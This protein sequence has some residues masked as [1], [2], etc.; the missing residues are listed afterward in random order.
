MFSM[1]M[2]ALADGK[3]GP[4]GVAGRWVAALLFVAFY[5]LPLLG[6]G[7]SDALY[8]K[9]LPIGGVKADRMYR[10]QTQFDK[11]QV[12]DSIFVRFPTEEEPHVGATGF[13]VESWREDGAVGDF[14]LERISYDE[15]AQRLNYS[16]VKESVGV[17]EFA[18]DLPKPTPQD[19]GGYRMQFKQ[20]GKVLLTKVIW[21]FLDDIELT[22]LTVYSGCHELKIV[23]FFSM[24]NLDISLE[25]FVY[26]NTRSTAEVIPVTKLGDSYRKEFTW[27]DGSGVKLGEFGALMRVPIPPPENVGVNPYKKMEVRVT[28][29]N[30][31]DRVF[32]TVST[33]EIAPVAVKAGMRMAICKDVYAEPKS[34][35][36]AGEKPVGECPFYSQLTAETENA[37]RLVWTIRN[38]A[39]AARRGAADTIF[40]ESVEPTSRQPVSPPYTLFSA[41]LY[42]VIL[43]AEN[44][45]TQCSVKDSLVV[46]IDSSLISAQAIPNV[47]TPNGDG[48][49]DVFRFRDPSKDVRSVKTFEITILDRVGKRVYYYEGDPRLWDGWNGTLDGDGGDCSRGVYFF[50]IRAEGYDEKLFWD[51]D[52]KGTVHLFR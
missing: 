41:G 11:K 3:R 31:F 5:F 46:K 29:V 26:Y 48:L 9:A 18:Y 52:Y 15:E 30:I 4:G 36:D 43:S 13:R 21:V 49:N 50:I 32:P 35:V 37:T 6:R 14:V 44:L 40:Q 8:F 7:Q 27:T 38:D 20:G 19:F 23:P 42:K 45:R 47:F 2:W 17:K 34:Y 51:G 12:Q 24:T 16:R 28:L 33:G 10:L 1:R 22:R 25:K 39:R